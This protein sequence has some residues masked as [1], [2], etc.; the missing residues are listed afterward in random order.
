MCKG[1]CLSSILLNLTSLPLSHSAVEY[2]GC[3][4][5]WWCTLVNSVI[6]EVEAGE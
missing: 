1:D 4:C 5:V 6:W 3:N 2:I